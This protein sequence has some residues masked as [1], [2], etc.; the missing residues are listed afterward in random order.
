MNCCD[1]SLAFGEKEEGPAQGHGRG[2]GVSLS[3]NEDCGA[4]TRS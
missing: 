2:S 4:Q 3:D 1:S